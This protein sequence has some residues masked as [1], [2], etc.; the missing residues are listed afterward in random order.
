MI[1]MRSFYA[2]I[3]V[4]FLKI[5]GIAQPN[6]VVIISDDMGWNG[7]SVQM[8]ENRTDSKSGLYFTPN[9]DSLMA[10][11]GRVFTKG[12]VAASKCAPSRCAIQTGKSA[13]RNHFTET[14]SGLSSGEIMT[15]AATDRDI[16]PSDTTL[17]EWLKQ[18]GQGYT[19]AHFGKWHLGSNGPGDHGFDRSD[20]NT[21][22]N[23]GENGGD[24]Q[25]DPKKMTEITDSSIAFIN[26]SK[27]ASS[28]FYLQVSH[29]AVHASV[30]YK[31]DTRDLYDSAER[32]E[33]PSGNHDNKDF[34]AMTEN[35][36]EALGRLVKHIED[37]GLADNTYIVFISD[38]GASNGMS[39]N[40]P[41]KRG[42]NHLF[43]GGI[44]VPF[45]VRGPWVTPNSY[46]ETP[47]VTYDLFPTFAHLTCVHTPLPDSM[48][49]INISNL[50]NET[51]SFEREEPLFF[52]SPH[53]GSSGKIPS[54]ATIEGD[55]KYFV[56]Y[57]SGE[58]T[59]HNIHNDIEEAL[60]SSSHYPNLHMALWI[61]LRDH[62]L[63]G[64]A[65]MAVTNEAHLN[66]MGVANDADNDGLPDDWEMAQ[67]LTYHLGP[68][69]D[70]DMDGDNNQTEHT[71]GTDPLKHKDFFLTCEDEYDLDN[72]AVATDHY[73]PA[74]Q[75]ITSS[76]TYS[77][78]NEVIYSAQDSIVLNAG[79]TIELGVVFESVLESCQ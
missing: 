20:G 62:L 29:Y 8:H 69:D 21:G 14:G 13:P 46:Q 41:L 19:T 38:N 58:M 9:I 5:N 78:L 1:L 11:K 16:N 77:G 23:D 65:R 37:E 64:S 67:L 34:A 15:A 72:W 57:E 18:T 10:K 7:T 32:P 52:H 76:K 71:N 63:E 49:G 42:K 36:D 60:D 73:V 74:R 79:F 53:Y 40:A 17:A 48:D 66:F 25:V 39:S 30:E 45:I 50:F 31:Q 33:D 6:F 35:F 51:Y 27:L 26:D 28:P 70:P 61:K 56:D 4:V 44:R 2:F 43:E 22:N 55:Y 47:V 75:T 59:L 12:Y 3:L 68:N 54:G 24:A